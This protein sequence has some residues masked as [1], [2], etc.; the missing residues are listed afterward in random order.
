MNTSV[1]RWRL[2]FFEAKLMSLHWF[3]KVVYGG[4]A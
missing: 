4:S 1:A 3:S 2:L